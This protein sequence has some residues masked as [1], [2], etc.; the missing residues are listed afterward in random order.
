M[1][2]WREEYQR[3]HGKHRAQAPKPAQAGPSLPPRPAPEAGALSPD[4]AAALEALQNY[5]EHGYSIAERG[6]SSDEHLLHARASLALVAQ[7]L[8]EREVGCAGDPTDETTMADVRAW[9]AREQHTTTLTQSPTMHTYWWC[10]TCG[11]EGGPYEHYS[12]AWD[13]TVAHERG[14]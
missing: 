10:C 5:V 2:E 7:A 11:D 1:A 14:A 8:A 6:H 3:P 4:V 13:A 9:R 12:P